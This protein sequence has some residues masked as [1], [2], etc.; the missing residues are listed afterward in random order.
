MRIEK[1]VILQAIVVGG[2]ANQFSKLVEGSVPAVH[3]E[4]PGLVGEAGGG[5]HLE[6]TPVAERAVEGALPPDDE[7]QAGGLGER[8]TDG[9]PV[10]LVVERIG[11]RLGGDHHGETIGEVK[12][13]EPRG[14]LVSVQR[15]REPPRIAHI[16]SVSEVDRGRPLRTGAERSASEITL[17]APDLGN[18]GIPFRLERH[19]WGNTRRGCLQLKRGEGE[20]LS[21][22][23]EDEAPLSIQR[24]PYVPAKVKI[25]DCPRAFTCGDTRCLGNGNQAGCQRH[26]R[27]DCFSHARIIS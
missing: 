17:I 4:T 13:R 8:E 3:A 10:R 20:L 21:A 24:H 18:E 25:P 9:F 19:G 22:R 5:G 23:R 27:A 6:V 15:Q 16:V 7:R 2:T 1:Q 12:A 11:G 26:K 14:V